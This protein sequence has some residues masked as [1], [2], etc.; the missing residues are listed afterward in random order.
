VDS[1]PLKLCAVIRAWLKLMWTAAVVAAVAAAAQL[2]VADVLGIIQ[3]TGNS[4]PART[5]DW[6]GLLTWVCFSFAV[7]VFTGA[8]AGR[9]E[10]QRPTGREGI[11]ARLA[12][13]LMAALGAAG[14]IVIAWLPAQDAEP[15]VRVDP[16]LVVAITAGAGVVLGVVV[17]LVALSSSPVAVGVRTTITWVWL[18]GIASVVAGITTH[19]A[20]APPRLAVLDAP[21]RVPVQWWSGPMAMI[22]IAAILSLAIALVTRLRGSSRFGVALSGF[23]GPAMIAAA[24]L[25]AGPGVGADRTLQSEPYQAALI[26]TGAGLIVSVIVAM[27]ARRAREPRRDFALDELLSGDVIE[28]PPMPSGFGTGPAADEVPYPRR[29][30]PQ[31]Q[32]AFAGAA[33]PGFGEPRS[34]EPGYPGKG[35]PTVGASAIPDPRHAMDLPTDAQPIVPRHPEPRSAGGTGGTYGGTT[36]GSASAPATGTYGSG[37]TAGST[38][39]SAAEPVMGQPADTDALLSWTRDLGPTGRHSTDGRHPR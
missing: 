32:Y 7:A 31:P 12:A 26:A 4:A 33:A 1:A 34:S 2:G 16:A 11:G 14:A 17:A 18:L 19:R 28:P 9:R 36:Y 22:G 13:T 39:G 15:P 30:Q 27:P 8:L 23:S 21:S 29:P 20:F 6:S 35:W 38:A 37:Y 25:I 3:W 10:L 24:Y 5:T